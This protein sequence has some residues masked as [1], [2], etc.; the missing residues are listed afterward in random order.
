M[1]SLLFFISALF[2]FIFMKLFSLKPVI[3]LISIKNLYPPKYFYNV[4]HNKKGN[5]KVAFF[6]VRDIY[7]LTRY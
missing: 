5:P 4:S 3:H 7:D 1:L 6:I 2:Y